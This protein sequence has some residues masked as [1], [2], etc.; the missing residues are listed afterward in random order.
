MRYLIPVLG[1]GE[2]VAS[3][4]IFSMSEVF[5]GFENMPGD[6]AD[7]LLAL[8]WTQ[9]QYLLFP[10]IFGWVGWVLLREDWRRTSAARAGSG[11][12]KA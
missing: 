7:T 1:C 6:L 11:S 12:D 10:L 4:F 2:P 8:V 9:Y 3:T 5:A